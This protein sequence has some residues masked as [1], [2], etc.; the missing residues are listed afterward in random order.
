MARQTFSCATIAGIFAVAATLV[1]ADGA[2]T[3]VP[4]RAALG[5]NDIIDWAVLGVAPHTHPPDPFLIGT[6][7]GIGVTVSEASLSTF[8]LRVQ[9][10]PWGGAAGAWGGDFADGAVLIGNAS[11]NWPGAITLDFDTPVW[12]VGTQINVFDFNPFDVVMHVYDSGGG[13]LGSV[14]FAGLQM[15]PGGNN[16]APFIG[17]LSDT[18]KIGHVVIDAGNEAMNINEVDLVVDPPAGCPGDANT[19]GVVDVN[20]ISY[21]LF[22]LGGPAPDGDANGDGVIDVND[23][24]YVLFRL[25]N[26]CATAA[27]RVVHQ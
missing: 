26:G 24:S 11:D 22:R 25:G 21:V 10:A 6:S 1:T 27:V 13:S 15:T 8:F 14:T 4:T 19:D 12:A 3:G 2:V 9:G 20:D 17:I 7:G 23:I 18:V 5:G 16:T